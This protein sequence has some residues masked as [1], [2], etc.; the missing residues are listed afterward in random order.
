MSCLKEFINI[1]YGSVLAMV[2]VVCR[3]VYSAKERS[4]MVEVTQHLLYV[5][6]VY[7]YNFTQFF[8]F[9]LV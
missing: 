4:L 7:N 5:G 1:V 8:S 2:M 6:M 3:R 9:A